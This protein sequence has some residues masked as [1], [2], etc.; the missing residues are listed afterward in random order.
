MESLG[1]DQAAV[2]R[3]VELYLETTPPWLERI[4]AA[5]VASDAAALAYA[6]HTLKGSLTQIGCVEGGRLSAD[7]ERQG[8][9]GQFGDARMTNDR[10]RRCLNEYEPSL[11]AWLEAKAPGSVS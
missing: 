10:L 4:D 7:L 9:A 11:R 6:A 2:R 8:K 5:L 3:L 1:G